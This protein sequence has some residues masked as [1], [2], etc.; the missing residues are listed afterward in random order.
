MVND[1]KVVFGKG[2]GSEPVPKDA[3]G[4]ALMWK[5]KLIFWELPY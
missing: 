2:Q 5:K 1:L 4:H 3:L